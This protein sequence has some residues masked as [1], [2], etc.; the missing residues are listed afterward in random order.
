MTRPSIR[1]RVVV[2]VL[3]ALGVASPLLLAAAYLITLDEI[4]EVLDDSLRQTAL[5]LADRD[6]GWTLPTHAAD[7]VPSLEDTESK[8]VAVAWRP[9]GSL[10]FSSQPDLRVAFS[11][12]PGPSMQRIESVAWHVFTVVQPDRVIQVA[13][14]ASVRRE[15]AAE[16]ATQ[17][18]LPL[19]VL[20]VLMGGLLLAAL[21]R[22]MAPL[23]PTSEAIARRGATSLEPLDEHHVPVE[24]LPMVR[25]L[26][27]LLRRLSAAFAAQRDFV[28]D[29]AHEL[30]SPVTAL[31]LQLQVLQQ[32]AHGVD[33]DEAMAAM[34]SGIARMRRLI[35]QLLDLSKTLE[36]DHRGA[37]DEGE[38][39]H[40]TELARSVVAGLSEAALRR[41]IDLGVEVEGDVA[42]AGDPAQLEMLLR[43][44]VE[45]ALK[46]TPPGGVVDVVVGPVDGA[47]AIRVIDDGPGIAPA[48]RERVFDRFYRSP[49]SNASADSG[50]GLGLAIVK[51]IAERHRASV[52]LHG[53]RGPAGLE[54]RVVF[55]QPPDATDRA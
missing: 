11:A 26:N 17:L 7:P 38:P 24:L 55:P 15:G 46:Y 53:G 22:G 31:Q 21:R 35:E 4:D 19:S 34:A 50:S 44:L 29:A 10:L 37:T 23:R 13:Q 54:V 18:V 5:L 36:D 1:R 45:N 43:N 12:T 9:D 8:L 49:E 41:R 39:V 51:A 33:R 47:P 28:A 25:T 3:A 20:V 16:A 40:L 48:E 42:V 2:W 52:T 27:D 30:R 6:L 14:P 32:S